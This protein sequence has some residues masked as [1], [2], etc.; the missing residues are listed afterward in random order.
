M[1]HSEHRE[2]GTAPSEETIYKL[3]SRIGVALE[4]SVER[5]TILAKDDASDAKPYDPLGGFAISAEQSGIFIK[6]N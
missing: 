4:V 6:R 2:P 3:L 1:D 5:S